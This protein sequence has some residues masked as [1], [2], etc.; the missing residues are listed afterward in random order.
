MIFHKKSFLLYPSHHT[1]NCPASLPLAA[2]AIE[3]L[4]SY[5]TLQHICILELQLNQEKL[6]A[7]VEITLLTYQSLDPSIALPPPPPQ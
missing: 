7:T 2:M 5:S 6:R 3:P 1:L 4:S